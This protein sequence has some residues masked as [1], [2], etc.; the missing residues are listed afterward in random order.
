LTSVLGFELEHAVRLL[1]N[2]GFTVSCVEYSSKKGVKGNEK[3]V[4]RQRVAEKGNVEL[5]YSI[6]K[7]DVN[8][9]EE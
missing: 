7:T 5:V 8:Y 2:G 9:S 6:F 1:E 4:I 3:R